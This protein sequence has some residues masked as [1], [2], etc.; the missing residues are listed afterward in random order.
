MKKSIPFFII[1]FF[2]LAYLLFP[3]HNSSIDAYYYAASIRHSGEL[4]H[5]HHLLYNLSGFLFLKAVHLFGIFPDVLSF[6]KGVNAL[7]AALCL[8]IV[9]HIFRQ[10]GRDHSEISGLLILT[11]SSFALWRYATENETYLIPLAFSLMASSFFLYYL[12]GRKLRYLFIAGTFGSLA[13]LYHQIHFFW[14]L[15]LCIGVVI[16]VRR[17]RAFVLYSLPIL[18]VPLVYGIVFIVLSNRGVLSGDMVHFVF[19]TE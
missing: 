12:N 14:W 5:P 8:V 4:F 11:G 18:L 10:M 19:I 17:W 1:I 9:R 6:L 15:G 16:H 3:S 7:V 2:L 13:I